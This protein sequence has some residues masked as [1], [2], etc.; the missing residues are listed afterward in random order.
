MKKRLLF[1]LTTVAAARLL[2]S[3]EQP[4]TSPSV[5]TAPANVLPAGATNAPVSAGETNGLVV[6]TNGTNLAALVLG[7]NGLPASG[8]ESNA[9]PVAD[10]MPPGEDDTLVF[11]HVTGDTGEVVIPTNAPVVGV[12]GRDL[13]SFRIIADRNIFNPNRRSGMRSSYRRPERE[14][15]RYTRPESFGL[16]GTMSYEKGRFA[17]FDGTSSDYRKVI[18]PAQTIAGYTV[19]DITSRNVTLLGTNGTQVQ[20]PV[21]MQMTKQENEP[22]HLSGEGGAFD[23]SSAAESSS[24]T[25]SPTTTNTEAATGSNSSPAATSSGDAESD[26]LKRL[27]QK[28]EEELK[29]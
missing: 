24:A 3:Q 28:R 1:A 12:T 27:L 8:S 16:V 20:L 7:T 5:V 21:G 15:R 23:R 26:V 11:S 25:P 13:Q 6:N 22:W 17:F 9:A 29:R 19:V 18:E 14:T 2:F 4:A 10:N